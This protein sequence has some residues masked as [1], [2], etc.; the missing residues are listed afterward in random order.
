MTS[1]PLGLGPGAI[2][3][4]HIDTIDLARAIEFYR[5]RLGLHL[6]YHLEARQV[7]FFWI[8][9]PGQA[10]LGVWQ[11]QPE[12]WQRAH[13][14]FTIAANEISTAMDRLC[15]A[16]IDVV[17]FWGKPTSDPTVHTWMPACGIFFRDPDG[18]SLEFVAMLPGP[19]RPD[20]APLPLSAWEAESGVAIR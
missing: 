8:G 13:F 6:A 16:G 9:E 19:G 5:D 18:N 2:Y 12:A 17:D 11:T 20:L 3:E 14:A 10:M 4:T 15:A 7:A 1:K